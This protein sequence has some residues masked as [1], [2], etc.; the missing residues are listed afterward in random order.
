MDNAPRAADCTSVA[1]TAEARIRSIM[2]GI[3]GL[4]F[5]SSHLQIAPN[6]RAQVTIQHPINVT[7]F[8]FGSMV[9]HHPVRQINIGS[10]LQSEIDVVLGILYLIGR[11]TSFLYFEPI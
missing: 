9:L 11:L 2:R 8:N 3:L 10:N 1:G 4:L 7:H 6:E 5:T